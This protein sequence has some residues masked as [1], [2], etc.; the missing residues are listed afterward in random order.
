MK[1]IN[2]LLL[3]LTMQSFCIPASHDLISKFET[4]SLRHFSTEQRI[5]IAETIEQYKSC[6]LLVIGMGLDSGL[7]MN[8]NKNGHTLFLEHDPFWKKKCR[9]MFPGIN[10]MEIEYS[11]KAHDWEN[12]L[13]EKDCQKFLPQVNPQFFDHRFDV[14]IIDG[15]PS[16][17]TVLNAIPTIGRVQAFFLIKNLIKNSSKKINLFV[18]DTDRT[19]EKQSAEKLFGITN[20]II[21]VG[22]LQHYCIAK[23][24]NK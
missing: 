10:I 14:V 7:W 18:H 24:E 5:L 16:Y 17:H 20:K 12:L 2:L 6:N 22:N 11:T 23:N 3:S 15:P 1:A 9:L 4:K 19:A 8:I 13:Q 21:E